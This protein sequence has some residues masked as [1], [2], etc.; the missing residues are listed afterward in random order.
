MSS[1]KIYHNVTKMPI[2]STMCLMFGLYEAHRIH[3]GTHPY[4]SP[5]L[6]AAGV[7]G[8]RGR[9]ASEVTTGGA[10][11]TEDA[12]GV[13]EISIKWTNLNGVPIPT[14]EGLMTPFGKQ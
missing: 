13:G 5:R 12:S 3:R 4:F 6:E 14:L 9:A 11:V 1:T 2:A 8:S 10:V 7:Q